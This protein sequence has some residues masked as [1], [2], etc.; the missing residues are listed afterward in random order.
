MDFSGLGDG[1]G[2]NFLTSVGNFANSYN[3]VLVL[4]LVLAILGS[5]LTYF[6]CVKPE[7]KYGSK[8]LD[9]LRAF[10]NFDA[11]VIEPLVKISYMFFTIYFIVYSFAFISLSF[12]TFL[13][14]LIVPAI[15]LRMAYELIMLLVGIWKN[16]NDITK[17]MK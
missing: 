4:A 8:F 1:M 13:Y 7:K 6:W 17:K 9:W 10:L 15:A 12:M 11:K 2:A 16:T 5:L 3:T 14:M